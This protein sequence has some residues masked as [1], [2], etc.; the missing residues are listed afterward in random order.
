MDRVVRRS[1]ISIDGTFAI[2]IR[3]Y[4]VVMDVTICWHSTGAAV[5]E[6]RYVRY[7]VP[8]VP[9]GATQISHENS[10]SQI[11]C[12]NEPITCS[13]ARDLCSHAPYLARDSDMVPGHTEDNVTSMRL[14]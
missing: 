13:M 11:S 14:Q 12:E 3:Y 8:T 9:E 4:E 5:A 7:S 6:S 10:R 2:V 1:V